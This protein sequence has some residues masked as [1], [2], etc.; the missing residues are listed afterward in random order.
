MDIRLTFF[1]EIGFLI[2]LKNQHYSFFVNRLWSG[3]ENSETDFSLLK[4]SRMSLLQR[5]GQ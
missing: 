3:R 5:F 4:T 2:S 1:K